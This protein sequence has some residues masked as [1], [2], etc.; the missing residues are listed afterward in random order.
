MLC[1]LTFAELALVRRF[2]K[3]RSSGSTH[4]FLLSNVF[5]LLISLSCFVSFWILLITLIDFSSSTLSYLTLLEC[6]GSFSG[7]IL[8][9]L[10]NKHITFGLISFHGSIIRVIN[11]HFI[12]IPVRELLASGLM[13]RVS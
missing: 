4:T 12:D 8:M 6:V 2:A 13:S 11:Q 9:T 1:T 10:N 7:T 3:S 5:D